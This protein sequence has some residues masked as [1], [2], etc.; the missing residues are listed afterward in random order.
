MINTMLAIFLALL[1]LEI[2]FLMAEY[3]YE[4]SAFIDWIINKIQN[5]KR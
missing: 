3:I 5:R 2:L 1:F 4:D